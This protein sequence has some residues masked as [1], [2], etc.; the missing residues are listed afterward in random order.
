MLIPICGDEM[1]ESIASETV[2]FVLDSRRHAFRPDLAASKLRGKVDAKRFV[3]S[4]AFQICVPAIAMKRTPDAVIGYETELLHEEVI[5]VYERRDGW[6]WGQARRDGYVGY[7]PECA[8]SPLGA[9]PTHRVTALRS[10]IYPSPS[11][12]A[13]PLTYLPYGVEISVIAEQEDFVETALGWLYARHLVPCTSFADD[14]VTEA[15]KF[16]G[17]P[18]LWGGKS[19]LGLD[20]SGLVQSVCFTCGIFSPRDSDMQEAELGDAITMPDNPAD[21][22]RGHLLFWPGHVALTQGAG[23]MIHA[24]AFHMCVTSEDM[25]P[26]LQR[27]S[28]K[29]QP[30]RHVRRLK[31]P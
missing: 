21:L 15:E 6:V 1:P 23:R 8:L 7:V 2:S 12:K 17:I 31:M 29:S 18:Y 3:D 30:L 27:I 16:L 13:T 5:D 28:L 22:P 9:A 26:A 20:C 11:I 14:P 10:F 19:S 24:N 25:T 4:Q